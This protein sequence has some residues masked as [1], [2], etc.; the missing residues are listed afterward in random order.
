MRATRV[1][2]A[3]EPYMYGETLAFSLKK[4][5]PDAEV[6][7]LNPS[8]DLTAEVKR[9][10][11][12]LVVSDRVPEEAKASSFWV[13]VTA[14]LGST[15]LDAEVSADGY[16][17]SVADVRVEHVVAALDRAGEELAGREEHARSAGASL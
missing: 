9:A 13:E 10:R 17:T 5:R 4:E 2:V 15:R 16:S 8:G 12:H 7:L 1:L 11:P 6:I 14:G 3:L